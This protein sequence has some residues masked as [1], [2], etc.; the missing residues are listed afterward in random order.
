MEEEEKVEAEFVPLEK[1]PECQDPGFSELRRVTW[2]G[3]TR[4]SIPQPP[5]EYPLVLRKAVE[6]APALSLF[7]SK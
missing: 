7:D 4:A 5:T 1:F 3:S 6:G 2:C